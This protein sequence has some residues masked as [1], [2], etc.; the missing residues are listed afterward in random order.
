M[1]SNLSAIVAT[2]KPI[3]TGIA[4]RGLVACPWDPI[5]LSSKIE[6]TSCSKKGVFWWRLRFKNHFEQNIATILQCVCIVCSSINCASWKI[7]HRHKQLMPNFKPNTEMCFTGNFKDIH[8]GS[9]ITSSQAAIY[10]S[11]IW[12]NTQF[13]VHCLFETV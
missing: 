5:T 1:Y 10:H 3:P 6:V 7:I 11:M 2:G 4:E 13:K 12:H 9:I 8:T